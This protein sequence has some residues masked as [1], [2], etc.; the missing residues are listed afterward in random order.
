M[1]AQQSVQQ[2]WHEGSDVWGIEEGREAP[3]AK[4]SQAPVA[5]VVCLGPDVVSEILN[6][7]K[8]R[9]L[10][11]LKEVK[12]ICDLPPYPGKW[13]MGK[14]HPAWASWAYF[15]VWGLM[16]HKDSMENKLNYQVP[17]KKGPQVVVPW[18]HFYY[19]Y[20][21]ALEL[22]DTLMPWLSL[23]KFIARRI[24][25]EFKRIVK[26]LPKSVLD[27]SVVAVPMPKAGAPKEV[28]EARRRIL[29]ETKVMFDLIIDRAVRE[30]YKHLEYARDIAKDILWLLFMR[31]ADSA[32]YQAGGRELLA[33]LLT[34]AH[35][36]DF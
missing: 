1:I 11:M 17:K 24:I 8:R 13:R 12:C 22:K 35:F 4:T 10:T 7:K 15:G 29:E 3:S 32:T 31:Y 26:T 23:D 9:T 5:G 18:H 20:K 6:G 34:S 14:L 36:H 16:F 33:S 19:A 2:R 25:A 27:H 30:D 28:K 21:R